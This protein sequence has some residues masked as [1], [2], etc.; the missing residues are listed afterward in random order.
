MPQPAK[1]AVMLMLWACAPL[2][3]SQT[4]AP[5]PLSTPASAPKASTEPV[6]PAFGHITGTIFDQSG[7]L[8][9]GAHITLIHDN[10]NM[11]EVTT[12]T[13]GQ[14]QFTNV[15]AGAFQLTI[16]F[17]GFA[18]HTSSGELHPGEVLM[19]NP[20]ALSVASAVTEVQV[21]LTRVE[22]AEEQI[23][24][25]EKQRIFGAIPNFYVTYNPNAEPLTSGQ[26]FRLAARSLIDPFTFVAVAGTAG[27][28]QWQNHFAAY[29]QGAD[30][31][32]KRF[33]ASFADTVS[34]AFV[35]GAILPALFKQDPRYFYKGTGTFRAR[36][37]YAIA[38]SLICKGD[39]R[40]WQP[41]YSGLLGS[42]A[43]GGISNIYYPAQDRGAT[44]V[45]ENAAINIAST[46]ITNIFQEFVIRKLTP[47][48][49]SHDTTQ[50]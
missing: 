45:F 13:D 10:Q 33:G 34:G 11:Q 5:T 42:V 50:N 4:P 18:T 44:L 38:M 47:S 2:A 20:I 7:A 46:A 23:K 40:R 26:K 29:G 22:V 36:A 1:F 6:Q 25:E 21:S 49:K 41:N 14:Y 32:A 35:G 15:P 19:L 28:E 39:N 16:A 3:L 12:N 43:A 48:A 9:S 30:G 24:I 37:A 27:I 8:V 17:A 31:Y